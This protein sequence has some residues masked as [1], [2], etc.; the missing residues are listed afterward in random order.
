LGALVLSAAQVFGAPRAQAA[1]GVRVD[2]DEDVVPLEAD[3]LR[4][5][6]YER[7]NRKRFETSIAADTKGYRVTYPESWSEDIVSLNDGKLYGVDLR[8]KNGRQGQLAVHVLPFSGRLSIDEAGEP[9]EAL[10]TFVPLVGAFW[11][12]NGFGDVEGRID[13]LSDQRTRSAKDGQ[14]YYEYELDAGRSH[15]LI[16]ATVSDGQLYLLVLSA[17]ARQWKTGEDVLRTILASFS[18]PRGFS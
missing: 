4:Y 14:L 13:E 18:V 2:E 8:F 7:S 1:F 17:S 5:D 11:D 10:E 16:S 15:N 6:T 3:S 9:V 12:E